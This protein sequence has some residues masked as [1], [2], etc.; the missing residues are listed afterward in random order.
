ML[1]PWR[2]LPAACGALAGIEF[3]IVLPVLLIMLGGV[4]DLSRAFIA[5][6]R[7]TVAAEDVALIASTMAVQASTLGTL[8]GPQAARA[9]TAAFALFPSWRASGA[10]DFS[11][12][13]SAVEFTPSPSGCTT[14]CSYSGRVRWSVGNTAGK[15][16]LRPCGNIAQA[17][18]NSFDSMTALPAGA[19]GPTSLLV[20]DVSMTF[21][22]LLTSMFTGPFPMLRSAYIPPRVSSGVRLTSIGPGQT[23]T[24]S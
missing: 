19:F 22:P 2:R 10:K 15:V 5:M 13:L 21:V 17:S 20:G 14:N 18:N 7:L 24:C 1:K 3:A 4:V 23:V 6:R 11:V 9:T 12:T 16:V 8:S